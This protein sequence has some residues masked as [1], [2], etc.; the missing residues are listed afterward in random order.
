[1]LQVDES[2]HVWLLEINVNP[3]LHTHCHVLD[4]VIPPIVAEALDIVI[5]VF[6]QQLSSADQVSSARSFER[7]A[8]A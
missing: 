7:L 4:D 2:L 8:V 3:A 5:E 6:D 1:M